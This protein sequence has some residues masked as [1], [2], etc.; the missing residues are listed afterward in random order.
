MQHVSFFDK[1]QHLDIMV[2]FTNEGRICPYV[3]VEGNIAKRVTGYYSIYGDLKEAV[4]VLTYIQDNPTIP[5]NVKGSIYKAF[6]TL[7]AKCF[8]RAWGRGIKLD[9]DKVFRD[10]EE[11][12]NAHNGV[13]EIRDNY[14]AH[15]GKG[16]YQF[17]GMVAYLNPD[18][19]NPFIRRILFSESRLMDL[20]IFLPI[21]NKLCLFLLDF[22]RNKLEDLRPHFNNEMASDD[23]K[24]LYKRAKMPDPKDFRISSQSENLNV[25][26]SNL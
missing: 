12:L 7:Y 11:L 21:Y 2:D 22:V 14:T 8:T 17:G 9:P 4:T 25:K 24:G 19:E 26:G 16:H 13:M 1:D 10:N 23:L 20:S 15:A 3:V 18:Q 6:I 5:I